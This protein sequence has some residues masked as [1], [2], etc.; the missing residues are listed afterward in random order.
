MLH[1]AKISLISSC[2][3]FV[4]EGGALGGW[5]KKVPPHFTLASPLQVISSPPPLPAAW[6]TFSLSLFL[7]S[8]PTLSVYPVQ[9]KWTLFV[10]L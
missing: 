6:E 3:S 1:V 9:I 8:F 4:R 7:G 5:K 10:Y 2:T